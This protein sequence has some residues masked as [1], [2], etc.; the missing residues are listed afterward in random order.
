MWVFPNWWSERAVLPIFDSSL[1]FLHTLHQ[2]LVLFP[3]TTATRSPNSWSVSQF[4]LKWVYFFACFLFML[5]GN[6]IRSIKIQIWNHD[7]NKQTRL[8]LKGIKTFVLFFR[9]PQTF[10]N[11]L[12]L[13][14]LF[15]WISKNYTQFPGFSGFPGFPWQVWSLDTW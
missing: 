3:F 1:V 9:F 14:W 2:Y 13:P 5:K 11:F 10:P 8:D 6:N 12:D 4:L 15:P 7:L